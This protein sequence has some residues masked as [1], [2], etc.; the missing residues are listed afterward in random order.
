[1]KKLADLAAFSR[2][3]RKIQ[4][5]VF[6]QA[7]LYHQI[8]ALTIQFQIEIQVRRVQR[9]VGSDSV[10]IVLSLSALYHGMHAGDNWQAPGQQGMSQNTVLERQGRRPEH[11]T[12]EKMSIMRIGNRDTSVRHRTRQ[13]LSHTLLVNMFKQLVDL[14]AIQSND[15]VPASETR[16]IFH[17][18]QQTFR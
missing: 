3:A 15:R 11:T 10:N 9:I 4:R 13:P 8:R 16:G 6:S 12:R 1:M 17:P 5:K 18:C 2:T 14:V 7:K